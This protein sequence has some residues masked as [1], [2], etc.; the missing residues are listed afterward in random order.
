MKSIKSMRSN[1][2]SYRR[3][4][5]ISA[6]SITFAIAFLV[7][8]VLIGLILLSWSSQGNQPPVLSV[9]KDA[10]VR[11]AEGQFYQPFTI[12]NIGGG[13]VESVQVVGELRQGDMLLESGE[14][15]IDYLSANE[16][17]EGAFVFTHDP[18]QANLVIRV[19]S[20]KLP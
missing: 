5:K 8:A 13:T 4:L 20:Y 1:T 11:V 15:Q 2:R 18:R 3:A 6:E 14:Q 7:V 12:K 9:V 17:E 19:A 10:E 16:Q